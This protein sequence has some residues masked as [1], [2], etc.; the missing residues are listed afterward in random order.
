[1]EKGGV[2]RTAL[3]E[4]KGCAEGQGISAGGSD[5]AEGRPGLCRE[6]HGWSLCILTVKSL[7]G[8]GH[9]SQ[10]TF[11]SCVSHRPNKLTQ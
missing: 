9:S 7:V 8:P 4:G 5:T 2:L 10:R 1:M 11:K 3:E 6:L